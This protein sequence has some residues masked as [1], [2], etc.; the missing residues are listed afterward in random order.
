MPSL[1]TQQLEKPS[2]DA[3]WPRWSTV[4]LSP[5]PLPNAVQ[6]EPPAPGA[7]ASEVCQSK[8]TGVMPEIR[9]DPPRLG[10]VASNMPVGGLGVFDLTSS[11][12]TARPREVATASGSLAE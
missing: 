2:T 1:V 5:P 7:A 3:G 11:Q 4:M 8:P 6:A 10:R 12:N 9:H